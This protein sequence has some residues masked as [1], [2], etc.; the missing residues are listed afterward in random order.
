MLPSY[1]DIHSAYHYPSYVNLLSTTPG[2]GHIMRGISTAGQFAS[3]HA[4]PI[5]VGLSAAAFAKQSYDNA[6]KLMAPVP[7]PLSHSP[8]LSSISP[9]TPAS[10]KGTPPIDTSGRTAR[11]LPDPRSYVMQ[12]PADPKR[13]TSIYSAL[14]DE[15]YIT[16]KQMAY[17]DK[18][19]SDLTNWLAEGNR[20]PREIRDWLHAR[21]AGTSDAV[22]S[23][24]FKIANIVNGVPTSIDYT[25][26]IPT[27]LT[28]YHRQQFMRDYA[29]AVKELDKYAR[30]L[31]DSNRKGIEPI[32]P[33]NYAN[34]LKQN[35][36]PKIWDAF[37][38]NARQY[39]SN[40]FPI[41]H[42]GGIEILY[43][44][45]VTSYIPEMIRGR[46]PVHTGSITIPKKKT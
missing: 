22:Q 30:H 9:I 35:R 38:S 1:V 21:T 39:Y 24:I 4:L 8:I 44:I 28:D 26:Y 15:P 31:I 19:F 14:A 7:V 13:N 23:S 16:R 3:D 45:N 34:H 41:K 12:S 18:A 43:P 2:I 27:K 29:P 6:Q 5:V 10:E 36:D 17:V 40:M 25:D 46:F 37:L 11:E 42:A 20:S 33:D 32:E